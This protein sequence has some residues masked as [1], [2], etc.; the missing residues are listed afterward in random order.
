MIF[1]RVARSEI[2]KGVNVFNDIH[3]F[4]VKSINSLMRGVNL[5]K[6]NFFKETELKLSR[7]GKAYTYR[8]YVLICGG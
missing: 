2:N 1:P 8:P 3:A 6:I 5:V 4:M 7:D